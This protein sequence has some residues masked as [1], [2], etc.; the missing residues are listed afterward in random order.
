MIVTRN[1]S[2]NNAS[3]LLKWPFRDPENLFIGFKDGQGRIKLF[4]APRQ[5]KR[6]RPLFQA[7]GGGGVLPH[8]LR[9]TPRLPVPRQ[10]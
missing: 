7:A 4:G 5:W 6:F 1:D 8:R 2:H 10:K 9:Q 3:L